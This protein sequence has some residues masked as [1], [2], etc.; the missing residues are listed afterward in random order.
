M[1]RDPT[2]ALRTIADAIEAGQLEASLLRAEGVGGLHNDHWAHVL[3]FL[4]WPPRSSGRDDGSSAL[5]PPTGA[6]VVSNASLDN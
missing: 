4:S 5:P 1:D 2:A 6:V 3:V